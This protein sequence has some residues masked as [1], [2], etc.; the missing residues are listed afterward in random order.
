MVDCDGLLSNAVQEVLYPRF[1]K[2]HS[3]LINVGRQD[4]NFTSPF[5][6]VGNHLEKSLIIWT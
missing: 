6:S 4:Y 1:S 5:F 3:C 2:G